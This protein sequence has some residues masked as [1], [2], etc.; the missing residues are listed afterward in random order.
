MVEDIPFVQ[1]V[2]YKSPYSGCAGF[3]GFGVKAAG[4]PPK[5]VLRV[6][7]VVLQGR[8]VRFPTLK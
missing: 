4:A 8:R 2:L 6:R 5:P 7:R 1:S 3:S